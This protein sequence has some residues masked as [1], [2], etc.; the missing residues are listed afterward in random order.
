MSVAIPVAVGPSALSRAVGRR[1]LRVFDSTQNLPGP[2]GLVPPLAS[3]GAD[4]SK[5]EP[6][7]SDTA[8]MT[9]RLFAI[10]DAGKWSCVL[11]LRRDDEAAAIERLF[12]QAD[13]VIEG[14]RPTASLWGYLSLPREADTHGDRKFAARRAA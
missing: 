8:R 12:A 13:V 7:A 11:D 2:V 3:L 6:P 5:I 14:F 10:V 4:A 1:W 9:P